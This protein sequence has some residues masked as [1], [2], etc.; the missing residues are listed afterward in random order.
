MIGLLVSLVLNL[1]QDYRNQQKDII[2]DMKHT[3]ERLQYILQQ[4]A[5]YLLDPEE[6]RTG[7]QEDQET[8]RD[9]AALRG[10]YRL[11]PQT[12][13]AIKLMFGI[14]QKAHVRKVHILLDQPS[15]VSKT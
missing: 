4:I 12:K 14:L 7:S 15:L 2:D 10:T 1:F 3:E 13:E 8:V 5:G 11:I 6:E 9:L